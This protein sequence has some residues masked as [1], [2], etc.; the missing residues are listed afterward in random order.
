MPS[1]AWSAAGRAGGSC[2]AGLRGEHAHRDFAL[3]DG[4]EYPFT[5][6]SLFPSGL[7]STKV[8]EQG[9]VKLS[10]SRRVRRPGTQELN[11]FPAFFDAQ[12]VFFGNPNLGPEYTDAIELALQR[13]GRIGSVQLTPFYRRTTDII[14]IDV[15]TTDTI[16]G[17]EVTSISFRNIDSSDSWGADLNGQFRLSPKLNGMAGLNIFRMVTDGG[18]ESGLSSDAVTWMGRVNASY[19]LTPETMVQ[20]MYMYRAPMNVERGRFSGMSMVNMSLRQKLRGDALTATVRVSDPFDTSGMRIEVGDDNVL[21]AHQPHVQQSG[22][23]PEPAG[24]IRS[25]SARAA[26]A[27]GGCTAGADRIPAAVGFM[28]KGAPAW[29]PLLLSPIA[30]RQPGLPPL[31]AAARA[32][33]SASAGIPARIPDCLSTGSERHHAS[34]SPAVTASGRKVSPAAIARL[35]STRP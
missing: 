6:R 13:S 31:R 22:H 8:G 19:T 26:A 1:T 25:G 34:V 2:R 17:R 14:R 11:P 20:G 4:A 32:A 24:D 27:T 30:R 15:N 29:R 5:Y 33:R 16:M 9:E 7:V 23:P 12:N 10:Y 28:K 3:A 18:S 21:P 35:L